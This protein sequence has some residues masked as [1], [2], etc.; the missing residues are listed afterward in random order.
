MRPKWRIAPALAKRMNHDLEFSQRPVPI[1]SIETKSPFTHEISLSVNGMRFYL[2]FFQIMLTILHVKV[3]I[4]RP[5]ASCYKSLDRN[6]V[7]R[8]SLN[9]VTLYIDKLPALSRYARV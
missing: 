8:I 4:Q 6:P 1:E 2:Y 7:I 3:S 5:A 9:E